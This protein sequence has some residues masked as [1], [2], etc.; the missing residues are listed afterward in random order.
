MCIFVKNRVLRLPVYVWVH[1]VQVSNSRESI[2]PLDLNITTTVFHSLIWYLMVSLSLLEFIRKNV[3]LW[4]TCMSSPTQSIWPCFLFW[5]VIYAT[6]PLRPLLHYLRLTALL[7]IGALCSLFSKFCTSD[8]V[9]FFIH[10]RP[11]LDALIFWWCGH[12]WWSWS[13][14]G[15]NW[16][17]IC[18]ALKPHLL[19]EIYCSDKI[20]FFDIAKQWK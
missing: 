17:I 12:F 13:F 8:E 10:L 2:T 15:H 5:L 18:K 19:I 3:K 16:V 6:C 14:L 7:L 4:D 11:K 1:S 9:A 20:V